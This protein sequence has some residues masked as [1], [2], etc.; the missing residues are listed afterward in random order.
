MASWYQALVKRFQK[1]EQ[2]TIVRGCGIYGIWMRG[3]LKTTPI[4]QELV[5]RCIESMEPTSHYP[6]FTK[7]SVTR[8]KPSLRLVHS[9]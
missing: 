1:P 3:N 6:D 4:T 2:G 8:R 5:D 7:V 9:A